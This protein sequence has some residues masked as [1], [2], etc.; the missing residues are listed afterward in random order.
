MCKGSFLSTQG[1]QEGKDNEKRKREKRNRVNQPKINN[2]R[3][4]NPKCK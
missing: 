2:R 1:E 4:P 3:G